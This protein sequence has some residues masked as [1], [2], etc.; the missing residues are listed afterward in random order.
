MSLRLAEWQ[1]AGAV[2]LFTRLGAQ[3]LDAL[4][5]LSTRKRLEPRE[6]VFRQGDPG[7]AVILSVR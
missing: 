1:I 6:I 7:D 5:R 2:T 3:H 4:V